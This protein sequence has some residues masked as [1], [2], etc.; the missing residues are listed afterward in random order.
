MIK[1]LIFTT[2]ISICFTSNSF[3]QS[4]NIKVDIDKNG[5]LTFKYL[6]LERN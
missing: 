4:N 2:V 1:K 6:A 3:G 5:K